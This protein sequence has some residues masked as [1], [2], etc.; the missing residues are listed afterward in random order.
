MLRRFL[1]EKNTYFRKFSGWPR[2]PRP[3]NAKFAAH[4]QH[5]SLE[6][7]M[8]QVALLCGGQQKPNEM[9]RFLVALGTK[10]QIVAWYL[11]ISDLQF[12]FNCTPHVIFIRLTC[13]TNIF[14]TQSFPCLANS[15]KL[16]VKTSSDAVVHVE[17]TFFISRSHRYLRISSNLT[18]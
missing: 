18:I 14:C 6:V 17:V 13:T 4:V 16:E 2:F 8:C 15:K 9:T 11:C 10:W 7:Q 5:W 3:S 1:F 12:C